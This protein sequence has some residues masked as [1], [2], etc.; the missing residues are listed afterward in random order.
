MIR[1]S[2]WWS[3]AWLT[4]VWVLA[5]GEV[6]VANVVVGT[7]LGVLVVSGLRMAPIR[8]H[9]RLHPWGVV[10]LFVVFAVDLVKA[11]FEVAFL[12]LHPRRTP[13]GAVIG[14]R[15]RSHSDLYLT[16][17]VELCSLVPGSLVIEA[18]RLTGM[19]YVHVL[20][21]ASI[22]GIEAARAQVLAQEERVLRA[23]ASSA[24]LQAAGL[25]GDGKVER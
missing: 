22:G 20:D 19:L 23:L 24:E 10:V 21:V 7:G 9:G 2:Q 15:L 3:V 13:H 18:H 14:V 11:S 4:T 12:A 8:F 5:W 16:L 17:T 6:S 25:L 1:R